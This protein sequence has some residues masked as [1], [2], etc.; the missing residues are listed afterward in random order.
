M[1]QEVKDTDTKQAIQDL[2]ESIKVSSEKTIY[3][4]STEK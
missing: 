4:L 2:A 1:A 3:K